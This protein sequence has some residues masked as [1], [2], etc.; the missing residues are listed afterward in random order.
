MKC[1]TLKFVLGDFDLNVLANGN[2]LR[3][4][5]WE[6]QLLNRDPTHISGS[7]LDHAYIRREA[8]QNFSLETIESVSIYFQDHEVV[9]F[10]LK[11]LPEAILFFS[12][13]IVIIA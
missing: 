3:N 5:L 9:K 1:L 10:K 12:K 13:N 11:L 4:I 6:Y 8:V 7:L 2:N